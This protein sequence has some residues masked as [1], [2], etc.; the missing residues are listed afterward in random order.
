MTLLLAGN[1]HYTSPYYLN[2]ENDALAK[3][4]VYFD[5]ASMK[6]RLPVFFENLNTLLAKLSFYKFNN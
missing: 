2:F 5:Q 4:I 6:D 3:S 1:G